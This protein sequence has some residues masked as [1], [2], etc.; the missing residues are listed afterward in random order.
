MLIIACML[1]VV[2]VQHCT[3]CINSFAHIFGRQP[4]SNATTAKDNWFLSLLTMGEGYHNY[5]HSFEWDYRNGPRWYNWDP[6]KWFI[7]TLSKVGL[8]SDLRRTPMDIILKTRF[9]EGR[10]GFVD[11][12]GAWGDHK[13][14]EWALAIDSKREQLQ[15]QREDFFKNIRQGQLAL[16]DQLMTAEATL[17][18]SLR[19]LKALRLALSNRISELSRTGCDDLRATIESEVRHLKRSVRNAQRATKASLVGWERLLRDY[20]QTIGDATIAEPA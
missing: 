19:E 17:E 12:M 6:T 8:T 13:Q 2:F 18:L 16:R 1:R 11:R 4:Y 7:W 9:E 5:H 20:A 10:R 15:T 14:Q 3:F